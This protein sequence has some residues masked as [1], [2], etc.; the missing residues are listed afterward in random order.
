EFTPRLNPRIAAVYTVKGKHHFRASVQNGFRFP[1]LFE[2]L[3]FV[4]N[5]NV[6]RVGGLSYINEGMGYLDNSY[7]LTSVNA[8]N[9]AVNRDVNAGMS[10]NDAAINNRTLLQVTNLRPTRPERIVS[11]EAGYKSVLANNKL[12][13]DLDAYINGYDGFLGQVE[14]AVPNSDRTGTE[15]SVIDMLASNR[16]RQTRYRV[17]T[18][19]VNSYRNYGSSFGLTWNFFRKFLL[20]GNV[21]YNNMI[22]NKKS[23]VFLTAFNTPVWSTNLSFGNRKIVKNTGFNI[24]WRWQ[25]SFFWESPLASGRIPSYGTV[26]AQLN[27]RFTKLKSTIK[28]GGANIFNHR[29]IQYAAG[30]T[31]G[32]LYYVAITVDGLMNQ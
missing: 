2:A 12:V 15:A 31:I 20:A 26:D 14:V 13:L 4:N 21:N 22:S 5:G 7:T 32:G 30:P 17:F 3:S 23:D 18:N 10:A 19:A 28:I 25:S 6:R 1:A 8:F 29:F 24:V 9:A 11:F 16:S 27:H